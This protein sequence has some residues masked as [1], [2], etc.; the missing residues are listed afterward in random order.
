MKRIAEFYKVSFAQFSKDYK[1]CF[2]ETNLSE[3]EIKS[4]YD[5][6][7]LPERSTT[8][9]A[10]YDLFLPIPITL[11]AGEQ[12]TIPTG[13]RFKCKKDYCMFVLSRSGL[14]T[15]N[16]L[17]LNTAISLIDSDYYNSSNEGHIFTRV[18]HDD[19]NP[20]AVL[21]LDAGKGYLQCV[22]VKFGITKSD[23]AFGTRNGGFGSTNR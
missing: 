6:I 5:S 18:I 14:G 16:R 23:R 8:G 10:G 15:R 13:I 21:S 20:N 11:R 3:D 4:I 17:Q 22:F 2:P 7:K 12:I 1:E 9:S 19:R